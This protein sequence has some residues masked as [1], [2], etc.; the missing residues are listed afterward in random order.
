MESISLY[1]WDMLV[2]FI[3]WWPG[4]VVQ[5]NEVPDNLSLKKPGPC[6]FVVKFYGTHNYC[7]T[8]HGRVLPYTTEGGAI[9]EGMVDKRGLCA[10]DFIKGKDYSH[11]HTHT[12][13]MCGLLGESNRWVEPGDQAIS[14]CFLNFEAK[15]FVCC[16]WKGKCICCLTCSLP[17]PLTPLSLP[18]IPSPSP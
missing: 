11:T 9:G 10:S 8:Y 1:D 2:F 15:S 7:W 17:L 18:L 5:P 6:M 3:R 4:E 13:P 12:P 16:T 14:T